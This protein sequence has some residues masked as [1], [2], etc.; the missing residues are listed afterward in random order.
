MEKHTLLGRSKNIFFPLAE[1]S[2]SFLYLGLDE[3]FLSFVQPHDNCK[4]FWIFGYVQQY[5]V[6]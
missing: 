5:F 1:N 6:S 4:A 3:M 2:D